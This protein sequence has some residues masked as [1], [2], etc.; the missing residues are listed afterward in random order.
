MNLKRSYWPVSMKNG[1]PSTNPMA[2][3]HDYVHDHSV[4]A[5]KLAEIWKQEKIKG[6]TFLIINERE[7][8]TKAYKY[9]N[10]EGESFSVIVVGYA[11]DDDAFGWEVPVECKLKMVRGNMLMLSLKVKM[12]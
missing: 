12:R 8:H 1:I 7:I 10:L 4:H 2:L 11:D 3:L 9:K 5:I 6:E